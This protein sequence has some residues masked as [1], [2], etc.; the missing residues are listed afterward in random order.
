MVLNIQKKVAKMKYMFSMPLVFRTRLK[1]RLE[2]LRFC[3]N[4]GFQRV[5]MVKIQSKHMMRLWTF[6]NETL[7]RSDQTCKT[8]YNY[9][10]CSL[11]MF[12]TLKSLFL[13]SC[14]ITV[15]RKLTASEV[16]VFRLLSKCISREQFSNKSLMGRADIG[17][18]K[19]LRSGSGQVA[20]KAWTYL[21]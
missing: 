20:E 18:Q 11:S 19:N 8:K 9:G 14:E 21:A 17:P 3:I 12:I 13:C 16:T 15:H 10:W 5:G 1:E 4:K 7:L 2:R 6:Q